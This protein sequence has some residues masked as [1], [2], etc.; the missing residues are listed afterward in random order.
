[1]LFGWSRTRGNDTGT[2]PTGTWAL[3]R[4]LRDLPMADPGEA[5]RSFFNGLQ[6]LNDTP[7]PV[8]HR[9]RLMGLIRPTGQLLLQDL[10]RQLGVRQL[11]LSAKGRKALQLSQ[12]LHRELAQGYMIALRQNP[13]GGAAPSGKVLAAAIHGALTYLGE[14]L[15]ESA[16]VYAPDP[17]GVW[18]DVHW[19]F[20]LA[21]E[22]G[23]EHRPLADPDR[24]NL[25]YSSIAELY[26]R[27]SL[28]AISNPQGLRQGEAQRLARYFEHAAR[29]CEVSR[30]PVA[31]AAG[32]VYLADLTSDEPPFYA[33]L[34]ELRPGPEMRA[35][36][37]T[38]LIR[39]LRE[40]VQGSA[41]GAASGAPLGADLARRVL[42]SWSSTTAKRRFSRTHQVQCVP[43]AVG[44]AEICAALT[45]DPPPV[46]APL[47]APAPAP[48]E[49]ARA[50]KAAPSPETDAASV[51]DLV[52]RGHVLTDL[53]PV[54]EPEPVPPPLTH[55]VQAVWPMWRVRDASPGGYALLWEGEAPARAQ[56]GEI[57]AV[58]TGRPGADAWQIGVIR[59]MKALD[60]SGLQIGVQLLAQRGAPA[61]VNDT[62]VAPEAAVIVLPAIPAGKEEP[63]L[64][65]PGG[66]LRSGQAL[67]LHVDSRDL[68]IVIG[69]TLEEGPAFVMFGYQPSPQPR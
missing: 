5:T 31:D 45:G 49:P 40:Q 62:G 43:L 25:P 17:P 57:V 61:R 20:A 38:G 27:C 42:A 65:A 51:W 60:A 30:S 10:G 46:H 8:T 33:L 54:A 59:W 37:L 55:G 21:E 3:R 64:L 50:H 16:R 35:F 24:P 1:M 36:S 22:R 4:W 2:M 68:D 41:A 28:L 63:R 44:F 11:P 6:Q 29:R 39:E 18:R 7:L 58:G 12:A 14:V 34:S 67:R 15:L 48:A 47:T 69:R 52:A 23:I 53:P 13:E 9:L 19:L 32:G 66:T 26:T 56:V